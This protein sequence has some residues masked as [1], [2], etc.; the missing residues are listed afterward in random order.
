M[1][2]DHKILNKIALA[3]DLQDEPLPGFSLVEIVDNCRVLIERHMGVTEYGRERIVVKTSN[4]HINVSGSGMELSR[5]TKSQLVIKGTI[6]GVSII[7][8]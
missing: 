5:M 4:G 6:F 1:A 8:E 3:S 2:R 7:K